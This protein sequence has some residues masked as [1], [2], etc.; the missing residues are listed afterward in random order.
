MDLESMLNHEST[1]VEQPNSAKR[2]RGSRTPWS[3]VEHSPPILLDP[4]S[5]KA[6]AH[7]DDDP[8]D[9][10]Y[11]S[12]AKHRGP[13]HMFENRIEAFVGHRRI[14]DSP[15]GGTEGPRQRACDSLPDPQRYTCDSRSSLSSFTSSPYSATHSRFSSTSTV[16]G[17][18]PLTLGVDDTVFNCKQSL[19]TYL[20][21]GNSPSTYS[22]TTP[23]VQGRAVALP[24]PEPLRILPQI[25]EHQIKVEVQEVLPRNESPK[26][27]MVGTRP[28]AEPATDKAQVH[29]VR[30][31]SPSDALIIRRSC[32]HS[33]S[34]VPE[35]LERSHPDST[36][37]VHLSSPTYEQKYNPGVSESLNQ[38]ISSPPCFVTPA[39][40]LGHQ[41]DAVPNPR[42][43]ASEP[44]PPSS[45]HPDNI[46]ADVPTF[47]NIPDTPPT[48][49]Y[50]GLPEPRCMFMEG[51]DTNSVPRKAV[52]HIFGRNKM[53]TRL[54]P[55]HVWVRYCRKHYQ[56]AVYRNPKGWPRLQCDLVQEQI[57]RLEMWTSENTQLG[58]GGVL[59]GWSL[60]LR[61]REQVR[62]DSLVR[63]EAGE[64]P[65]NACME[66][67]SE[68]D[69]PKHRRSGGHPPIAVPDW[70]F[71]LCGS[72]Y[73]S[74]QIAEI[75]SAIHRDILDET[76]PG[77]P[78][79]ELLPNIEADSKVIRTRRPFATLCKPLALQKSEPPRGSIKNE[80][81]G[82]DNKDDGGVHAPQTIRLGLAGSCT[83][84]KREDEHTQEGH[85]S[86]MPRIHGMH[87]A[88][89]TQVPIESQGSH[90][91]SLQAEK[92][93][94]LT[95]IDRSVKLH[96]YSQF[97]P[98]LAFL[99][100][101]A[102]TPYC[103]AFETPHKSDLYVPSSTMEPLAFSDATRSAQNL[104]AHQRSQSDVGAV[105]PPLRSRQDLSL[106]GG[107]D[108]GSPPADGSS[109]IRG[110]SW[111][112]EGMSVD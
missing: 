3:L 24:S 2:P 101:S 42:C 38:Q 21:S 15:D 67:E 96:L 69:G 29:G 31:A 100:N 103:N 104:V 43:S 7:Y 76:L 57:K 58:K 109:H 25:A 82:H 49:T 8:V 79:I 66:D 10:I 14:L 16:S 19:E 36:S 63:T 60:A 72:G 81:R 47:Q 73:S 13:H 95:S 12:P 85:A 40:A 98:D 1:A 94:S 77:I 112:G 52:S 48:E 99:S 20:A 45:S 108:C 78:D 32:T 70:L 90:P 83:K 53:C 50:S 5:L 93:T 75:I 34:E 27:E 65:V 74:E 11:K 86:P 9:G 106:V 41:R 56:R 61:R 84:R 26:H 23:L 111:A 51:C 55:A 44:T 59:R 91:I 33:L 88:S 62:R 102:G 89:Q 30:S 110:H 97:N 4:F 80:L 17:Y 18:H 37:Y 68:D 22:N 105:G 54:I 35:S 28:P 64:T 107:Y 71:D 92:P 87:A 46:S 6:R 39:D